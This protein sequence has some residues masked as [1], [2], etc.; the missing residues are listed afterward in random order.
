M[1]ELGIGRS[2]TYEFG[3]E[4]M[5]AVNEPPPTTASSVYI[6]EGFQTERCRCHSWSNRFPLH[7]QGFHLD[8]SHSL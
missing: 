5:W 4:Y 2:G 3:V 1:D 8:V 7:F 6:E